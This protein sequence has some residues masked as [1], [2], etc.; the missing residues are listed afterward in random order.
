MEKPI[1]NN[2]L[3]YNKMALF[4]LPG[5]KGYIKMSLFEVNYSRKTFFMIFYFIFLMH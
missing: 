3:N 1:H 4:T 5:M 2:N